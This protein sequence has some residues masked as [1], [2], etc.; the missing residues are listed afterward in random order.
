MSFSRRKCCCEED[1]SSSSSSP[2][3]SSSGEHIACG[4]CSGSGNNAP[5]QFRVVI[6]GLSDT[7]CCD[8]DT[9]QNCA[10]V[11][12]TYI[13][14]LGRVPFTFFYFCHLGS[15]TTPGLACCEWEYF[16]D[17]PID[18]CEPSIPN[19]NRVFKIYLY[20]CSSNRIVVSTRSGGGGAAC[21]YG[22]Q[23]WF[24][25]YPSPVDCL[26]LF[27]EQLTWDGYE[28]CNNGGTFTQTCGT[29]GTCHVTSI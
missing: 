24:K 3:S 23:R 9:P 20:V 14:D 26:S 25:T 7:E 4:R 27:E 5:N 13:L 15:P 10:L 28:S 19:P 1:S 6:D 21:H 16:F 12:G 8:D 11:N 17:P 22:P 2:S 29:S 18:L